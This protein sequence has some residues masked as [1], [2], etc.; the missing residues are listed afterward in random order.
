MTT[1]VGGLD[2]NNKNIINHL[3][4]LPLLSISWVEEAIKVETDYLENESGTLA[5]WPAAKLCSG[6]TLALNA[7]II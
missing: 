5:L 4:K 2:S 1:V 7:F 3:R 6:G